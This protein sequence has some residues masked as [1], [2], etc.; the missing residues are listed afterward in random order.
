MIGESSPPVAV[1]RVEEVR[2][3]RVAR[4]L[5]EIALLAAESIEHLKQF[6]VRLDHFAVIKRHDADN[7]IGDAHGNREGAVQTDTF[8]DRS[9]RKVRIVDDVSNFRQRGSVHSVKQFH[10]GPA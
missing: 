1:L 5:D 4:P 8:G 3:A 6:I 7:L 10:D 9:A 2:R